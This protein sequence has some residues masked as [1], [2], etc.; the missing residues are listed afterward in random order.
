MKPLIYLSFIFLSLF[1]FSCSK[2]EKLKVDKNQELFEKYDG[3][4]TLVRAHLEEPHD[5]NYDGIKST[6]LLTEVPEI[7]D[8]E[9]SVYISSRSSFINLQWVEQYS[10]CTYPE[11]PCFNYVKQGPLLDFQLNEDETEFLY[12]SLKPGSGFSEDQRKRFASPIELTMRPDGMISAVI[13]K[14]FYTEFKQQDLIIEA[15]FKKTTFN[16]RVYR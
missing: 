16:D 9:L 11:I 8:S 5:L 4:Y 6:N 14:K 10:L 13:S 7:S 3:D 1:I 15:V 12:G 2:S